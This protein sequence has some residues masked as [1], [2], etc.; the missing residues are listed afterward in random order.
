M[1]RTLQ[2]MKKS[3][4]ICGREFWGSPLRRY[5][6][7]QCQLRAQDARRPDPSRKTPRKSRRQASQRSSP[8][9]RGDKLALTTGLRYEKSLST[10]L[11]VV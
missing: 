9:Q 5:C 1:P 10:Y 6:S 2:Q 4:S 11:C 3:C 7:H 8:I